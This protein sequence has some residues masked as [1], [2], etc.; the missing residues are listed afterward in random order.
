MI[1]GCENSDD[2][3]T[4]IASRV[5]VQA[6]RCRGFSVIRRPACCSCIGGGKN[7][8]RHLRPYQAGM[9]RSQAPLGT[10][11]GVWRLSN[12]F[13]YRGTSDRLPA[14]QESE[15]REAGLARG[16]S[17]LQQA[18]CLLCGAALPGHDDQRRCS[19]N[20]PGLEDYQRARQAVH[21]RATAQDWC[22]NSQGYW[23]GRNFH[24]QGAHLS[25]RCQ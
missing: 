3:G 16:Q 22:S 9:V 13:G 19:R 14:V 2:C 25:D 24:T 12:L 1:W 10:R 7:G 11:H 4:P 17:V 6:P 18:I 8:L 21:G 15:A 5:F 23:G 20:A